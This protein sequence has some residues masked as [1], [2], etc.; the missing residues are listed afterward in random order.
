MPAY[1]KQVE[2]FRR[3]FGREMTPGD[4]FFFDPRS[5]TPQFRPPDD[6]D[7][8]LN[9][10]MELMAEAGLEPEVL[11]AFKATGGLFPNAANPLP[12]REQREWDAAV[13]EYRSRLLHSR[14][15]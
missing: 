9:V 10:L 12:A 3:K 13:R 1:R 8:A 14:K 7:Q 2:A 4:P 5:D 15:Q 11:Y 6:A